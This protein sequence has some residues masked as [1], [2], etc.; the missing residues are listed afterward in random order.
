MNTENN[1]AD[2]NANEA[3]D[4]MVKIIIKIIASTAIMALITVAA[5]FYI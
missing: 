4:F 5:I 2:N 1:K 3:E